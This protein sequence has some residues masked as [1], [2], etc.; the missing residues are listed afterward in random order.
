[1]RHAACRRAH[2]PAWI[3]F[4]FILLAL[5]VCALSAHAA[6]QPADWFLYTGEAVVDTVDGAPSEVFEAGAWVL[7]H[8]AWTLERS[9]PAKGTMV[10]AWRPVKHKL[11]RLAAGPAQVRVAVAI[12]PV[13]ERRSAVIVIGGIASKNDLGSILPLARSAGQTECRGY[14]TE[15]RTRLAEDRLPDGAPSA[16]PRS[17]AER[18]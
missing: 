16:S 2:G 9:D 3:L 1:M 8:D 15:L 13:G 4:T 7:S 10:T 5:L 18:R 17:T 6:P 12:K 11:V 14:V